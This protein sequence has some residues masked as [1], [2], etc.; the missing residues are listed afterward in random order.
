MF[1]DVIPPFEERG[2]MR[3]FLLILFIA[4][5]MCLIGGAAADD[6]SNSTITST[7]AWVI[8]NGNS[9]STITVTAVNSNGINQIGIPVTFS[10]IEVLRVWEHS[11]HRAVIP[12][13]MAWRQPH[14][15]PI[16]RAATLPS[17]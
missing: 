2:D 8:A 9:Q 1:E 4:G 12:I 14:S 17:I 10:L 3:V 7:Q 13:P 15:P 11:V 5:L 6:L 16:K